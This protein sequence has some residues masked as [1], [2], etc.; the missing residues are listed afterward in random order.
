MLFKKINFIKDCPFGSCQIRKLDY[1]NVKTINNI[2]KIAIS[3]N[4]LGPM[5]DN[6][7]ILELNFHLYYQKHIKI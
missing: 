5:I 3:N 7:F 6:L 2:V 4:V 1:F